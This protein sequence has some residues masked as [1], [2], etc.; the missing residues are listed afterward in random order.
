M[1]ANKE[2]IH[3]NNYTR[4]VEEMLP[5]AIII[6]LKGFSRLNPTRDYSEAK[7]SKGRWKNATS[8]NEKEIRNWVDD[9]GFI[10][11]II[12]KGRIV[13][14]IDDK[15]QGMH[16]R[17]LLLEEF[18]AFS[19]IE[20]PNGWQFI[21]KAEK[22]E[23]MA[24]RQISD[25]VSG[26]G[27]TID[28]RI[29]EKGYIVFPTK[30]TEGRAVMEM[31]DPGELPEFLHPVWNNG[32]NAYH[33]PLPIEEHSRNGTLYDLARRLFTCGME[34]NKV[35]ESIMLVYEHFVPDKYDLEPAEV[36]RSI[37]SAYEKT[38]DN[39]K[40]TGRSSANT[41]F[42]DLGEVIDSPYFE[43]KRF[44]PKFLAD[45]LTAE[46]QLV[47][48]GNSL[49]RYQEGI[50]RA[51][52]DF[53]IRVMARERLNKHFRKSYA[54]ETIHYIKVDCYRPIKDSEPDT[55]YLNVLNGLL[56]WKE[57]KLLPHDPERF[58]TI[59]LPILFDPD[60]T[61]PKIEKFI[62][63]VVPE[64]TIP[65]I[66]EWFGYSVIPSTQY[67]KA[68]MLTG[69]GSN[70]K[71]KFIELYEKFLGTD[72]IS[73]VPLQD[74]EGN[75]FKLAQ[76]YGK[77]A[78]TFADIPAKSLEKS[79]VFKTVVSGDRTSAE[80]KG[81]DSFDFKPFARLMFSAN[82]LPRSADLSEGFFRRWLIIPFPH[83]FGPGGKTGDPDIM[84]KLLQPQELSG[85]L[86]LAIDGLRRLHLNKDFSSNETTETSRADYRRE[87]DNVATF[88]E[89]CCI[90][91]AKMHVSKFDL[92]SA[93]CDWCHE[94]GYR[95]IGKVKYY[96]RV[97]TLAPVL[98]SKPH[99]SPRR[100]KGI[101]I[102]DVCTY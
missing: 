75:R 70:G 59:Q 89:E 56:D 40:K 100:Y 25:Y 2:P 92:Y 86:N 98:E 12:P 85:L 55:R 63:D 73:N 48:D 102:I 50:Y 31:D 41:D 66:Y 64:D 42:T 5:G 84:D 78:N 95:P 6:P 65:M 27:I 88:V 20:T 28:T 76:I 90:L 33:L 58:S 91:D 29:A 16:L 39:P 22:G 19:S 51:I 69:S 1:I 68:V 61:A 77:L 46:V 67:Q 9:G 43:G 94:S 34:K 87:I 81:R 93:Y 36:A 35:V 14:D 57:G 8:M 11:A 47:F 101:G 79:S 45:E 15:N 10:G 99:G 60:A 13:I 62:R 52:H 21:F 97:E 49:Y 4:L 38:K 23:T 18:I 96:K 71:S 44:V 3:I 72:N 26:V 7:K 74:L 17:Q 80:F 24:V 32:S 82:E 83:K 54:D 30:N 37:E 53:E